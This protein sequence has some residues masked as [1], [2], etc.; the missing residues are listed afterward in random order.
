MGEMKMASGLLLAVLFLMA[1]PATMADVGDATIM[2]QT[3]EQPSHENNTFYLWGQSSGTPCWGHFNNSD[4][5]SAND[6]YAESTQAN[7][8]MEVEWTCRMDPQL[9]EDFALEVDAQIQ[10]HLMI[11]VAG[12]WENG[13]NNCNSDCENLNISLMKGGLEV[14]KYEY[15]AMSQGE[16]EIAITFPVN[17]TLEV[18]DDAT[19]NPALRVRMVIYASSGLECIF[20]NCDASFRMYFS[21]QE[22]AQYNGTVVFPILNETAAEDILGTGGDG[23][24]EE[25]KGMPGFGIF[26]AAS[27]I[28]IAAFAGRKQ[29]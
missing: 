13:Q 17:E 9:K 2:Q 19:D 28:G 3:G 22:E 11:D 27:A 23:G 16:N 20:F 8:K 25:D 21:G 4:G 12:N 6:G 5:G 10:V 14:A 26:A 18:W 7:G 1:I 29:E 15:T 24:S